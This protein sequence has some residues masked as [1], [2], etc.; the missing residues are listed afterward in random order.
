MS[1]FIFRVFPLN[2][3]CIVLNLLALIRT[4]HVLELTRLHLAH[5]LLGSKYISKVHSVITIL[6]VLKRPDMISVSL[7]KCVCSHANIMFSGICVSCG[8]SCS[9]YYV[10]CRASALKGACILV[11]AVATVCVFICTLRLRVS[12]DACIVL[13][14]RLH[15]GTVHVLLKIL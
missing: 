12:N 10:S 15:V 1:D 14:D 4:K 11:S 2:I 6:F 13:C 8:D 5:F 9:V 7:F 3:N